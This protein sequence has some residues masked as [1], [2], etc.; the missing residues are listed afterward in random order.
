MYIFSHQTR[1]Q[2]ILLLAVANLSKVIKILYEF[3]NE[4]I[5]DK[6]PDRHHSWLFISFDYVDVLI[7]LVV[8][9]R[10]SNSQ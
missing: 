7:Y 2:F 6:I 5:V 3:R 1:K 4:I 10:V 9:V 8:M